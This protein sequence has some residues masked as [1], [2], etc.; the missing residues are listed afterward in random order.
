MKNDDLGTALRKTST[1]VW[2]YGMWWKISWA[3]MVFFTSYM[4]LLRLP[5]LRCVRLWYRNWLP[6]RGTQSNNPFLFHTLIKASGRPPFNKNIRDSNQIIPWQNIVV[7][8][9]NLVLKESNWDFVGIN[10]KTYFFLSQWIDLNN[11]SWERH[12][13]WGYWLQNWDNQL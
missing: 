2:V 1:G 8:K 13:N 7:F 6:P 12:L 3:K 11:F 10:D 9:I 5:V 4:K